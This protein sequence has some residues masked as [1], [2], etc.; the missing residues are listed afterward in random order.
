MSERISKFGRGLVMKRGYLI[1]VN[2]IFSVLMLVKD[3]P[4]WLVPICHN[5]HVTGAVLAAPVICFAAVDLVSTTYK[6]L[7][8]NK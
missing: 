4:P 8:C 2:V 3:V 7:S 6:A 5:Q 1:Q